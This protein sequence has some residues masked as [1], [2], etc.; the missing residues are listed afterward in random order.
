MI[1]ARLFAS[2]LSVTSTGSALGAG[3]ALHPILPPDPAAQLRLI[4][5]TWYFRPI[6]LAM[7]AGSALAWTLELVDQELDETG[8]LWTRAYVGSELE[9]LRRAE[10]A[11]RERLG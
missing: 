5:A 2:S 3:A 10:R 9:R 7:L 1:P 6:H 8:E 11:R 4:A